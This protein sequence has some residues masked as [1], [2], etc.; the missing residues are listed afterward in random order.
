ML[1]V[2]PIE[3]DTLHALEKHTARTVFAGLV[4]V[5][6]HGHFRIEISLGDVGIDHAVGF[7]IDRPFEVIVGCLH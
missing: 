1:V 2:V 7:H 4:F 3:G 5:P 6:H